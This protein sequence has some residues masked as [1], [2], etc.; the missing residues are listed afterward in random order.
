VEK[1]A[2]KIDKVYPEEKGPRDK[3]QHNSHLAG[4]MA[5]KEDYA[6]RLKH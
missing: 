5:K 4:L 6:D 3:T 2:N 1:L